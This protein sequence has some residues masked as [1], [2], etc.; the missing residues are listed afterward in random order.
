M[1]HY[2][3]PSIETLHQ[4]VLLDALHP[5]VVSEFRHQTRGNPDDA[6]FSHW[7]TQTGSAMFAKRPMFKEVPLD[8]SL[9]P[10]HPPTRLVIDPNS[11]EWYNELKRTLGKW[12]GQPAANLTIETAN[13]IPLWTP[14]DKS[15]MHPADLATVGHVGVWN[16]DKRVWVESPPTLKD[17]PAHYRAD[18]DEIRNRTLHRITEHVADKVATE[19]GNLKGMKAIDDYLE[20]KGDSPAANPD[21]VGQWIEQA[22]VQQSQAEYGHPQKFHQFL[23]AH[24]LSGL[25][26]KGPE[27]LHDMSR[28]VWA[29]ALGS[30]H[31]QYNMLQSSIAQS[32]PPKLVGSK[33]ADVYAE[34]ALKVAKSGKMATVKLGNESA[35][36]TIAPELTAHLKAGI[37][38][39][40]QGPKFMPQ[41]RELV[42]RSPHRL[43]EAEQPTPRRRESAP[44]GEKAYMVVLTDGPDIDFHRIQAQKH[45]HHKKGEAPHM[46]ALTTT[47][48]G[49]TAVTTPPLTAAQMKQMEQSA[50]E[51]YDWIM[52]N[53]TESEKA[54]FRDADRVQAA[55]R[56]RD[57]LEGRVATN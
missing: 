11:R 12:T 14:S 34:E 20:G 38:K 40:L 36:P 16:G 27:T 55:I 53:G 7:F 18:K 31:S 30:L 45:H 17:I 49:Q 41:L 1:S 21:K 23:D 37:A 3:P 32:A 5:E 4:K 19:V 50:Q 26:T 44:V 10:H 2:E 56:Q 54:I 42:D 13:R 52:K 28:I 15:R 24:A 46:T 43:T 8:I 33:G 29:G 25:D 51:V 9:H 39:T 48:P 6:I 35:Q 22:V 47:V 57:I